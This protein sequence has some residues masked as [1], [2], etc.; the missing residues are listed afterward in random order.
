[1]HLHDDAPAV[2]P[3]VTAGVLL[4]ARALAE[5]LGLDMPTAHAILDA[6]GASKSRAYELAQDL[7]ALLPSLSRPPGRPPVVREPAPRD[8]V[9]ALRVLASRFIRKHPGCVDQSGERARYGDVFRLFVVELREQHAGIPLANFADAIDVPLGTVED[10]LR[11]PRPT[12]ADIDDTTQ[13]DVDEKQAQVETV[14][15]AWRA[16]SGGFKSF[17]EHVRRDHRLDF[18]R[19]MI[20]TIL[21]AHGERRASPRPG[22]SRDEEALRNSFETFFPGAQWV[23]DGKMLE[24]HVDGERFTQ[25]LELIVDAKS[26]AAVG[27]SVRDEEDSA[28]VVQ[29]FEGGKETTGAGPIA[30]LLDN[31]PS[32]HTPEVDAALGE[33]IRMRATLGRPQ[34]KAHVEGDFGLFAQKV[35]AI[36]LDTRDPRYLA[37]TVASLIALT[38][39]RAQN[40]APRRDRNGFTR[41][42]LYGETVTPEAR[43]AARAALR[44][45]MRKLE[46]ARQTRAARLDPVVGALLDEA[47]TRLGLLD[48]E[49]HVRD[50]I[51]CYRPDSI[52]DGI[53]IFDGKRR[54]GT[55]PAGVDA[56]YLLGIVRNVEHVH[57]ADAI[58]DA[59]LRERL[60]ARDRFLAPLVRERDAFLAD[61][62]D[63]E[64]R[65]DGLVDRLVSAE[66]TI[67][68]IFWLDAAA[69][70]IRASLDDERRS[71]LAR[72]AARRI[73][74][75]FRL[76]TG[77]R[78]RLVR[79]LLRR[80]CPLG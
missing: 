36:V 60:A 1:M 35:P 21:A 58:V 20:A 31:R 28:A 22:R 27:I 79:A 57:E 9:D 34:N 73:N 50:A 52:V 32:N 62:P 77:E 49:R 4:F 13:A 54:A 41:V 56:R 74:A 23:G 15:A 64:R 6:T 55:L 25:N 47:F 71:A 8:E 17:C 45:R 39:F 70:V 42:E 30:L 51:A 76:L 11:A 80:I 19:T 75:N 72:R 44:E 40:H 63:A 3:N 68:R 46:L 14:L 61:T 37:R 38:F 7:R 69:G 12:A 67:D 43:E 29:A 16:W 2:S 10:W 53:A 18:G 24:V 48:P 66:R 65:L 59:L 78:H 33:T 26:A 5:P